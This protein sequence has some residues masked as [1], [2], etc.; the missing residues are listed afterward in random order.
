[1]Y[2]RIGLILIAPNRGLGL[3]L[4]HK[5]GGVRDALYLVLASVLAFRLT[6]LVRAVASMSR[7]SAS[8]G[9][10]QLVAVCGG[11]LRSAGLV[12]LGAALAIVIF[13][14]RGRRDPSVGL[15]LGAACYVPW[16]FTWLPARI[17]DLDLVLGY[18]PSQLGRIL[19]IVAWG[20]A[21]ILVV[22]AVRLVRKTGDTAAVADTA[23][24]S[25][26]TAPTEPATGPVAAPASRTL[27]VRLTGALSL[28]VPAVALILGTIFCAR[29]WEL[30]RPLGRSDQAPDFALSRIDGQAG[31]VRLSSLRGKVVLLDFWATW[32]PPCLAMMPTLH[33][34]HAAWH[35]RGVE[36]VGIDSDGSAVSAEE[37][38]DFIRRRPFPYPIVVDDGQVGSRYGV[39]SLPH[40]VVIGR[41][42]RIARVFVGGVGRDQLSA[43]L[44]AA[45]QSAGP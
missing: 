4:K 40:L 20:W 8:S 5:G 39:V 36:F 31:S 19:R 9:L 18:V 28:A 13:S 33:D 2:E 35:P 38:R 45:E 11:E 32:C 43:A 15:E 23:A 26:E 7:V 29:H 34:L 42:G 44:A 17:L 21:G 25:P 22:L 12:V 10:T 37:V 3:I 6:D 24:T 41:D 14:G 16:F 27:A 30:L 1:L